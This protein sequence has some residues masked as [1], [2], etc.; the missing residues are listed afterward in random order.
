MKKLLCMGL[1]LMA[2]LAVEAKSLVIT[3]SDGTLVYYLLSNDKSPVMRMVPGGFT[4]NSDTYQFSEVKNFYISQT[5]DPNPVEPPVDLAQITNLI[6]QY[7]QEGSTVTVADI[8]AL[9]AK[10]LEQ[11]ATF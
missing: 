7:L 8:T 10:Y 2:V 11:T 3:L 9:I 4:V 6:D 1:G 5:D